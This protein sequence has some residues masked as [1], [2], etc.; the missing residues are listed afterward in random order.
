MWFWHVNRMS[1]LLDHL[2]LTLHLALILQCLSRNNVFFILNTPQ[3]IFVYPWGYT[4]SRFNT[5]A[6]LSI[7]TGQSGFDLDSA[8][9]IQNNAGKERVRETS[10]LKVETRALNSAFCGTDSP[11]RRT[12]NC[13]AQGGKQEWWE[14]ERTKD[15]TRGGEEGRRGECENTRAREEV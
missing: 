3:K 7:E 14:R 9:L 11:W 5:T 2:W 4:N 13:T 1:L 12:W 8:E 15:R 6:I 10:V